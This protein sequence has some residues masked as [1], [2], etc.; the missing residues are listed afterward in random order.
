M[1]RP[2]DIAFVTPFGGA[3]GI[4]ITWLGTADIANPVLDIAALHRVK[5]ADRPDIG[6]RARLTGPVK[7][8]PILM[9]ESA[10]NYQ[11]SQ[12]DLVSYL[13]TGRPSF[14]AAARETDQVQTAADVLLP[15]ISTQFGQYLRGQ[16]G[17][18]LDAVQLQAGATGLGDGKCLVY[19][20][21]LIADDAPRAAA[22]L[23]TSRGLLVQRFEDGERW[24]T[25]ADDI[26]SVRA[27][28]YWSPPA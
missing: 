3:T 24:V 20:H 18:L 10:E 14:D 26:P 12:S 9:L 23:G 4:T 5:Q 15:T 7:P 28:K 25:L 16:F 27:L 22:Y 8:A 17:S 2:E 11:L 21:A 19:R 13:V 6:V 1:S